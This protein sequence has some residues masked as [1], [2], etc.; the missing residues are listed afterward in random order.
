MEYTI[1]E[2]PDMNDSISRI[3]LSGK[4]YNIRFTYNDTAD[5][6]KVGLYDSLNRPIVL[7]IKIVPR[8]PLNAFYGITE[9][10]EGIFGVIS[11]LDRIGRNDF[12]NGKAQFVFMPVET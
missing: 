12:K 6:W 11:N 4:V 8:F 10:P 5:Y 7:G 1:I 3:V 2:I 9:I